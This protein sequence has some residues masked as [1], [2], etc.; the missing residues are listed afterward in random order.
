[1][2][3]V[4]SEAFHGRQ[5]AL[6]E[7]IAQADYPRDRL[8]SPNWRCPAQPP[9]GVGW[10]Y[11]HLVVVTLRVPTS[12]GTIEGWRRGIPDITDVAKRKRKLTRAEKDAKKARREQY[13]WIFVRGKQKRVRRTPTIDGLSVDEFI[14][15]NADPLWLHQEGLWE[16]IDRQDEEGADEDGLTF[17]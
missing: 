10:D 11:L 2:L 1:M 9:S 14:L 4:P 3:Q 16:Y 6:K 5:P 8:R 12:L 13:E 17:E 15:R 7:S